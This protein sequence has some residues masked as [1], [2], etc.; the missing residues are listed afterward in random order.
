MQDVDSDGDS[1]NTRSK[2]VGNKKHE[3]DDGLRDEG[4]EEEVQIVTKES[5]KHKA[6]VLEEAKPVVTAKKTAPQKGKPTPAT[7]TQSASKKSM[8]GAERMNTVSVKEEKTTQKLLKLKKIK[9]RAETEKQVVKVRVKAGVKIQADKLKVDIA[10]RKMEL[11][12]KLK[13]AQLGHIDCDQCWAHLVLIKQSCC[14]KL[15]QLM[16]WCRIN[17]SLQLLWWRT[18]GAGSESST[19]QP[20]QLQF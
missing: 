4:S 9:V 6:T 8:T 17:D 5:T 11:E 10:V 12:Y 19:N 14:I 1:D 20:L 18:T 16:V 3:T 7:A 13:M 15:K 2:K